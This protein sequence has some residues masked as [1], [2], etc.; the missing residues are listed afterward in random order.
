VQ[1]IGERVE[2]EEKIQ[3]L[4]TEKE[5]LLKEVHHRV[6]NNMHVMM[7]LLSLQAKAV[8]EPSAIAA[9]LDARDRMQSMRIL[10]DKLYRSEKY[11]AISLR[12][13]LPPL[14]EEITGTFPNRSSISISCLCE[15]FDLDVKLLAPLGIIVNE[16]LS[17]VMKHAFPGKANG[18]IRVSASLLDTDV[19]VV[20]E[21]DGVGFPDAPS[22][23]EA[24]GFGLELVGM[25]SKQLGGRLTRE[26]TGGS[27]F[28]LQF[29][30]D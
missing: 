30:T 4:L 17:N 13:Y 18:N 22:L 10:Y 20:V 3:R 23:E 7:S 25:L 6:K 19:T 16:L 27:K 15:D 5:V 21:D 8:H 11:G 24:C 28:I 12:D 2:A 1:D 9:L 14:I 26:N 29:P